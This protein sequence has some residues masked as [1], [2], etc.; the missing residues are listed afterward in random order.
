MRFGGYIAF[1]ERGNSVMK[2]VPEITDKEI[3]E[4]RAISSERRELYKKRGLDFWGSREFIAAKAGPFSGKILEVGSGR[5]NTA[6]YLAKAGYS[7]T[8]IDINSE[9]LKCVAL[10]LSAEGLM[11]KADLRLMDAYS[12]EFSDGSFD[13]VIM[14][15]ALHHIHD[16]E[17]LFSGLDRVLAPGG[18]IVLADFNEKGR[19]I[20]E[21][22]HSEEGHVHESSSVGAKEAA[23]WLVGHGYKVQNWDDDCHW[24]ATGKK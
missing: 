5:G 22:V 14:I 12:M 11:D 1:K 16:V 17:K 19:T 2:Y 21:K 7:F 3:A 18:K 6:L 4:N 20:V 13:N 24:L 15:E 9:M 23:N 10:N 8:T